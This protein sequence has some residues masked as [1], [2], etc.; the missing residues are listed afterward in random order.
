MLIELH[1][2]PFVYMYLTSACLGLEAT[3][4]FLGLLTDLM[5]VCGVTQLFV[6]LVAVFY[7][8]YMVSHCFPDRDSV[9]QSATGLSA[10]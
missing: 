2:W 7:C 4:R 1:S 3:P 8:V 5:P 6:C 9:A 10:Q